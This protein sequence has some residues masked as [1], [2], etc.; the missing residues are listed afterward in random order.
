[1]RTLLS[2]LSAGVVLITLP[3]L[4][5]HSFE[6]EFDRTKQVTLTGTITKFEWMNPHI[7]VYMDVKGEDGKITKWQF[8]GGAP[9]M[10]KRNGWSR[11]SLK[12]G[13]VAT[14]NGSLAK[15][16]TNTV[17]ATSV[18]LADGRRV[19]AGSSDSKAKAK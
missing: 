10:L 11:N 17:N 2:T 7:W 3:L 15:D 6:A 16:G 14:I 5:H 8:E 4:A 19:L 9:N 13:D 12:E 1:M 18:V